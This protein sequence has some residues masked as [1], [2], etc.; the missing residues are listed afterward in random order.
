MSDTKR[1]SKRRKIA[2][3]APNQNDIQVAGPSNRDSSSSPPSPSI[4]KLTA[5]CCYEI[6]EYLS[7]EDLHSFSQTCKKFHKVAG[8]YFKW[9]YSTADFTFDTNGLITGNGIKR[10]GQRRPIPYPAFSQYVTKIHCPGSTA[11]QYFAKHGDEILLIKFLDCDGFT[12]KPNA[13]QKIL[14]KIEFLKLNDTHTKFQVKAVKGMYKK[15]SGLC[16]N[17]KCLYVYKRPHPKA[18]FDHLWLHQVYPNLEQLELNFMPKEDDLK[19]FFKMNPGVRGVYTAEFEYIWLNKDILL[20]SAI[21]LDLLEV[22]YSYEETPEWI[23]FLNELHER[24]FYKRLYE[25]LYDFNW[26]RYNDKLPMLQGLEK[27][28]V[29]TG[30]NQCYSLPQLTQLKRLSSSKSKSG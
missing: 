29:A 23:E 25:H 11:S 5:D 20:R 17:L 27:L 21:K 8:E 6:F 26:K 18:Y 4:F 12:L 16:P 24:G 19:E 9:N 30:I 3:T 13:V 28:T 14:P 10:C 2:A 1:T 7:F 22:Y 15:L